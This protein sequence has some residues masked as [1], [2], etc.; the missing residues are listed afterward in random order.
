MTSDYNIVSE[1]PRAGINYKEIKEM[2]INVKW[3]KGLK[4]S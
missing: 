3:D 4:R 1:L 2:V